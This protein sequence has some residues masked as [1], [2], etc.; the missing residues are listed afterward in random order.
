MLDIDSIIEKITEKK[1]SMKYFRVDIF[2][3]EIGNDDNVTANELC[4]RMTVDLKNGIYHK[5]L[6]LSLEKFFNLNIDDFKEWSDCNSLGLVVNINSPFDMN[7]LILNYSYFKINTF[8]VHPYDDIYQ[9]YTGRSIFFYD[10]LISWSKNNVQLK[11]FINILMLFFNKFSENIP[12]NSCTYFINFSKND[13]NKNCFEYE[14]KI[15]NELLQDKAAMALLVDV[16]RF[17]RDYYTINLLD[18][19]ELCDSIKS[20]LITNVGFIDRDVFKMNLS[21]EWYK[22]KGLIAFGVELGECLEY[23]VMED[24]VLEGII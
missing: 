8:S 3:K 7:N 10:Q 19:L 24:L 5:V 15:L 23:T 13:I 16:Y 17:Y 21:K 6:F 20:M 2:I 1:I 9:Q 14:P 22:N 18:N 11:Q 4:L 12:T